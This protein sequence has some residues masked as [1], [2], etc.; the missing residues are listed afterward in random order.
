M[1]S[2]LEAE[3]SGLRPTL[4]DHRHAA[5]EAHCCEMHG[6]NIAHEMIRMASAKVKNGE[7]ISISVHALQ[8]V[9]LQVVRNLTAVG[10]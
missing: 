10:S 9:T 8:P 3:V 5:R 2:A 1:T 7:R 6:G 4:A